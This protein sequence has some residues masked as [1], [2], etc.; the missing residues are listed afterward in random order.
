MTNSSRRFTQ[1][2]KNTQSRW[3]LC[4]FR[5]RLSS[6]PRSDPFLHALPV[7]LLAR[8]HVAARIG[9]NAADGEELTRE[10]PARSEPADF[11]ERVALQNDHLLV[12]AIGDQD[13]ALLRIARER[14]VPRR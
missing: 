9:R 8:V 7:V 5:V 4:E 14:E 2:A 3:F 12:V 13:V 11:G 10:P 6:S 1:N